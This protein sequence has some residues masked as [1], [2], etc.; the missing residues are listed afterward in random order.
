MSQN[1]VLIVTF[2]QVSLVLFG[3]LLLFLPFL[4]VG[5]SLLHEPQSSL[6]WS[7]FDVLSCLREHITEIKKTFLFDTHEI[8][9][10]L[11]R[12]W[13][14]LILFRWLWLHSSELQVTL[15][16]I[17]NLVIAKVSILGKIQN[18]LLL[19]KLIIFLIEH[20]NLAT[21]D[22]V[23]FLDTTLIADDCFTWVLNPTIQSD[24]ELIDKSLFTL[25]EEM[26]EILLKL[27]ELISW[28]NQFSLHFGCDLLEELEFFNNEVVII[29]ESL[30]DILFDVVIEVRLNM[31]RFVW[32][33]NFLDPHI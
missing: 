7:S 9:C 6:F 32:F 10:W 4:R 25:F 19:S 22:K 15:E 21:I 31:E 16:I 26:I 14:V 24:D 30:I 5:V 12:H 17:K 8:D 29:E 1:T 13:N 3:F 28:Q 18:R 20:F 23:H 27:L 33:L 11:R 2:D